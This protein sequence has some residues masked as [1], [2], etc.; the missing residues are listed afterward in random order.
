MLLAM[1]QTNTIFFS[2]QS[3]RRERKTSCF[4]RIHRGLCSV[5]SLW[6]LRLRKTEIEQACEKE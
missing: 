4:E 3:S 2:G 5:F 1:A 6:A